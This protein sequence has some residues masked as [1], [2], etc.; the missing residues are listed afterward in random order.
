LLEGLISS[1]PVVDRVVDTPF[2]SGQQ[3][4]R[5]TAGDDCKGRDG[6]AWTAPLRDPIT[7]GTRDLRRLQVTRLQK[8]RMNDATF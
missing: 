1:T 4:H 5:R 3:D 7:R 8:G 2:E 6:V